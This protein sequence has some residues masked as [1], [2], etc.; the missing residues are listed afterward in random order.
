MDN[1]FLL[2]FSFKLSFPHYG[3]SLY[4]VIYLEKENII[5]YSHDFFR[6]NKPNYLFSFQKFQ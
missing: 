1:N 5:L 6:L 4:V 3:I 2:V